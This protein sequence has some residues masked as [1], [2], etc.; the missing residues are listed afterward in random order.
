MVGLNYFNFI[1]ARMNDKNKNWQRIE[2]TI[3]KEHTQ[4]ILKGPC[5]EK[6]NVLEHQSHTT[7]LNAKRA[8][9]LLIKTS[10]I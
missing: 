2:R 5:F 8:H 9:L 7:D 6:N 1:N 3:Q 10:K 4:Y